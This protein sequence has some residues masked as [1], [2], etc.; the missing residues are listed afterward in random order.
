[1]AAIGSYYHSSQTDDIDT[2]EPRSRYTPG[3]DKAPPS[4]VYATD[5]PAYAATHAFPWATEEGVNL[6]YD[7][8]GHVKLEVPASIQD[9][10]KQPV[11]I[12]EVSSKT[13]EAVTSDEMGHNFRSVVPVKCLAKR[14]FENVIAAVTCYGGTVE[15]KEK[16]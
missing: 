4:S 13:F 9:R 15:I 11:F 10:L 2:L 14:R 1:M 5:D 16:S 7:D 6:Y 8:S 12:Y 3:G